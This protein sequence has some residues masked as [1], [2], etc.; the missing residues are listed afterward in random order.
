MDKF[1]FIN[2]DILK[3]Y[4][5][6]FNKKFDYNY[7]TK[8][9]INIII[10]LTQNNKMVTIMIDCK[11]AKYKNFDLIYCKNIINLFQKNYPDKLKK[12]TIIN[13]NSSLHKIF[14]IILKLLDKDTRQ[15]VIII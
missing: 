13:L 2:N 12:C 7:L 15:K 4:P 9:I 14:K 11:N 3:I 6:Y 10:T 5:C 1:C 8:K